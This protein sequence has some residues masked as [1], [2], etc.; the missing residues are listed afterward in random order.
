MWVAITIRIHIARVGSYYII[1]VAHV[2]S[3]YIIHVAH[4]GS[5]YIIHVVSKASCLEI[6]LL[7]YKL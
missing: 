6:K 1:H 3:Y 5:Y 2:G 4:V 7:H